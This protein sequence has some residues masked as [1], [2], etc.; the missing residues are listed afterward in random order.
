MRNNWMFFVEPDGGS[1]GIFPMGPLLPHSLGPHCFYHITSFVGNSRFLYVPGS[2]VLQ[3]AFNCMSK[4]AGALVVWFASGSNSRINQRLP[5]DHVGSH[6][7]YP[8]KSAKVKHISSVRRDLAG[9]FCK[10]K[11][12]RKS[13]FPMV[14]GKISSFAL[15]Q[16][17]KE[18]E[19]L[20][21][22]PLL[23][24]AAALVP[25]FTNV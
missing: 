11:Y 24:L 19:R 17:C 14:F 20:Q 22:F 8:V 2:L 10:S 21:S 13:A 16:I 5:G 15:K 9:F 7:N 3:E 18:S 23:S 25:P 12:R 4:F 1:S 6:S